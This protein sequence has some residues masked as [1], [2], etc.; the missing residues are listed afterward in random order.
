MQYRGSFGSRLGFYRFFSL[1]VD[2]W[3]HEIKFRGE[4]V[5]EKQAGEGWCILIYVT[6]L[7]LHSESGSWKV[8]SSKQS[9]WASSPGKLYIESM[10]N[11]VWLLLAHT[12]K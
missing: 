4:L 1:L 3:L 11:F 8:C 2:I 10:E 12:L 5:Q 7:F 9:N 6:Y